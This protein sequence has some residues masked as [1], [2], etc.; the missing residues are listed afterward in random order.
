MVY[1]VTP[2]TGYLAGEVYQVTFLTLPQNITRPRSTRLP[3]LL[4]IRWLRST[5]L[6][7]LPSHAAEVYKVTPLTGYLPAEVYQVTEG[8]TKGLQGYSSYRQSRG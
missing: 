4:A 5:R 3:S 8:L 7:S 2:L 1:K 6:L